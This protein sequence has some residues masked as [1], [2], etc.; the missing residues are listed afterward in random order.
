MTNMLRP[1][2]AIDLNS[3]I[4]YLKLHKFVEKLL[5]KFKVVDAVFIIDD[6]SIL[7]IDSNKVFKVSDSYSLVEVVKE[8]RGI[9]EHRGNLDLRSL[10]KLK[11]E[12]KRSVVVLVSDRKAK[13]SD[14][15]F[16]VFDGQRIRTL[17]GN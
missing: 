15:L 1:L 9:S 4:D 3:K 6:K 17:S 7:E 14:S 2:I 12:L 13:A 11:E 16:F 5:K 10:V 8:L